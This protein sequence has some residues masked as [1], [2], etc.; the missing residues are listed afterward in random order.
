LIET[1]SIKIIIIKL[2]RVSLF[3]LFFY[4]SF[5]IFPTL[6][7]ANAEKSSVVYMYHRFGE[8]TY[9]ST[10]IKLEQLESHLEEFS[11]EKYNVLPLEYIVES[12]KSG[13]DLPINTIGLSVD[14]A[15]KSFLTEGWPRFKKYGFPVTL[16]VSTDMVDANMKNYLNWD[17]IRQLKNE[18]VTIGAH[19]KTHPHLTELTIEE[20]KEELEYSN[21]R[22]LNEINVIPKLFAYPFGETNQEIISVIN[23]YSFIAAFG[24][25]SG[26]MGNNS[27]FFYLPRFSL[28]ERYGDIERVKFSANTKAIG[29][30]DFIPTDPVLSENPPF[31]G[32]SLLNKD[33]SNS[34]NCFIFDRKGAVDNE[35]MFFNERIEIRLKRKLSS[36][37]VRMNCTTQDSKGKWRWYGRQFILPEYLN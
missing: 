12:L 37:R 1:V 29:V 33:L 26:A 30:K 34:L 14:D 2:L 25:H 15:Y 17:E 22:Y 23:D 27:N 35:K 18:G 32:F 13:V 21:K 31:I 20:V 28:N 10:N 24:Q 6:Y 36:G 9:P 11:K 16:F 19:T 3:I 8:S 5:L 7:A 4:N